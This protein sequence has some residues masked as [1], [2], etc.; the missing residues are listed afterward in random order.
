MKKIFVFVLCLI[1]LLGCFS[2][3][4]YADFGS[5][6]TVLAQ[7]VELVKTG[8][9]GQKLHFTDKDFK[10]AF[11]TADFDSIKIVTLPKSTEGTLLLAG[12]RVVEGQTIK[13]KN[14]G[15]LVFVPL[16]SEVS[17]ASF[18]FILNDRAGNN[19]TKCRLRFI[20][21]VNYAP[22]FDD[23]G[24][25]DVFHTT[26]ENISYYG[27]IL[28]YEPEG[29]ELKYMVVEYPENGSFEFLDGGKY[30]YTPYNDFTGYDSVVVV[31]RDEYGN[32][33]GTKTLMLKTI[34][35]M[36][37]IVFVD[38][39]EREEYNAAV[40]MSALGIMEGGKVGD[41]N[42]FSPEE[43]VT[44]AEFVVMAM[45][46]AGIKADS[47]LKNTFFDDND[48]IPVS[49]VPYIATA[50]RIG[51]IDGE[52]TKEGLVFNPNDKINLYQVAEVLGR[53]RADN[54]N[55]EEVEEYTYNETVPIYA[56]ASVSALCTLGIFRMSAE[57]VNG[58][59]VPTR[60]E[61]AQYLYRMINV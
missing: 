16:S 35:R 54:T 11:A 31:A 27:E 13:R 2:S 50:Q 57:E 40:A 17:E 20:D 22:E 9:L 41:D 49:L 33:T 53:I 8:L 59:E 14:I 47:T 46:A 26:Q 7:D 24:S 44:K 12:R 42:Y 10:C 25:T 1:L 39:T 37:D 21:K 3:L 52:Y 48:K 15:S 58:L 45:K 18:T 38:M 34:E 56:R 23:S 55:T 28:V 61:I 32:Y 43:S 30:R 36:S 6:V 5:G 60:A 29:D 4:A 51:I 19:E